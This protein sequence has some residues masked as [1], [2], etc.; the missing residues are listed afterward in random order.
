MKKERE[1]TKLKQIIT[2]DYLV[3]HQHPNSIIILYD[4]AS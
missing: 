4:L 3:E 2:Q 1:T